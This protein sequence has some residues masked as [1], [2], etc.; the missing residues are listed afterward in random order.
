[1]SD[2]LS[3]CFAILFF[4]VS[5]VVVVVSSSSFPLCCVVEEELVGWAQCTCTVHSAQWYQLVCH[6][7]SF[8]TPYPQP[9][10]PSLSYSIVRLG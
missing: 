9:H 8:A 5:L 3:P 6:T 1:M 4:L 2:D 7:P 10:T